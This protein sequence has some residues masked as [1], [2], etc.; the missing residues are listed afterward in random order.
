MRNLLSQLKRLSL[1][2]N[3][4]AIAAA[5]LLP[6]LSSATPRPA[7]PISIRVANNSSWEIRHLYLS[8][9]DHDSWG[10]DQLNE[11][12]LRTGDS[13]VLNNVACN[14]GQVKVISEDKNGCFLST[15]VACAADATWTITNDATPDCGN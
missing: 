7:A 5:L 10:P 13:F 3:C 8:P 9:A 4:G 6:L 15:V 1:L 14:G 12:V 2:I 11:T